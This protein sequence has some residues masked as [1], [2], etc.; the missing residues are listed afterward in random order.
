[1]RRCGFCV[2][3]SHSYLIFGFCK[4]LGS[5]RVNRRRCR[6]WGGAEMAGAR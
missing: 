3:S 2:C 6:V 5:L 1:M 4:T